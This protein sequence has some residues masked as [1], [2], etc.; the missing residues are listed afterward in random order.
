MEMVAGVTVVGNS[1]TLIL[2]RAVRQG[3]EF[4]MAMRCI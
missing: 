1:E 2:P 3:Q 4:N